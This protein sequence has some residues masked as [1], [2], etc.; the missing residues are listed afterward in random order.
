MFSRQHVR[1]LVPLLQE[2]LTV[3]MSNFEEYHKSGK[4]LNVVNAYM[5]LAEDLICEYC[6]SV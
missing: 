5:A 4:S 2:N 3:L 1:K 6:F